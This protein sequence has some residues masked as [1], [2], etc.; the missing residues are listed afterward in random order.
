MYDFFDMVT[1]S[2]VTDEVVESLDDRHIN[3]TLD[4][5]HYVLSIDTPHA[6][7]SHCNLY[8]EE[9]AVIRF[10]QWFLSSSRESGIDNAVEALSHHCAEFDDADTPLL[11]PDSAESVFQMV[12]AL[13]PYSEIVTGSQPIDL[14]I[15][16]SQHE[17][18]NGESTALFSDE[19]M[20]GC[21]CIYQLQNHCNST[22]EHVLLHE[23]GHLLHMKVTG[24]LTEV[25]LSFKEY[26]C[27]LGTDCSRLSDKQLREIFADTFMLAVISQTDRFGD[28]LPQI[29]IAAKQMCF[30]YIAQL[31]KK[32]QD[33][34][35]D[36]SPAH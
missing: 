15:I 19:G 14:M 11:T 25:P 26:L 16:E 18:R 12:N 6:A 21:I 33:T 17:Y 36:N 28:P 22:P 2:A 3:A 4:F 20:K 35:C 31:A 8:T 29:S 23:L 9:N 32:C 10:A 24:T 7:T 30:R 1:L 5:A 34:S 27:R 13:F